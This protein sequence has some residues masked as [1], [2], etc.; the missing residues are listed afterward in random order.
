MRRG[1]YIIV[2]AQGEFL[3]EHPECTNL[4]VWASPILGHR[5]EE[6][7]ADLVRVEEDGDE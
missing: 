4:A 2:P 6:H 5:C 7:Q 3:C 1:D